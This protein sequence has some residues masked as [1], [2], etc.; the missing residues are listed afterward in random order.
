MEIKKCPF[1]G[2]N[3]KVSFKDYKFGGQNY[4]GDKE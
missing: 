4:R 2:G 3:A 1:C